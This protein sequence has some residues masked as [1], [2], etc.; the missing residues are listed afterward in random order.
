MNDEKKEKTLKQ[1]IEIL[2]RENHALKKSLFELSAKYNSVKL[3]PFQ[4]RDVLSSC[5]Q[6]TPL[7]KE[8]EPIMEPHKL[9]K[10]F[11]QK[12]ELKGHSGAV[13]AVKYS[14]CGKFIATGSFDKTVR[15]WDAS[16]QKKDQKEIFCLEGHGLNISD[17]SWSRCSTEILSGGYD[18]TCKI[19]DVETGKLLQSFDSDGF[20]QCVQ[21]HPEGLT[22]L[23]I[24]K[25]IFFF[26]TSRNFLYIVD[27]RSP[28][29][30]IKISNDSMINTI[31][32]LPDS[33][34]IISGDAEGYIKTWN[35]KTGVAMLI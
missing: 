25:N 16:F 4:L 30:H 9:Q 35:I 21:F 8:D 19:W 15:I 34:H 23:I 26:G 1:K 17:L 10:Y 3:P 28:V 31:Y 11:Y 20:V 22:T 13:Y 33:S 2:E 12:A 32:V 5:D 24:D 7:L 29:D 18:Q 6:V 27:R 14:P